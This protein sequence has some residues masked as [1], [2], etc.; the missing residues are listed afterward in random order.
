MQWKMLQQ[1]QPMDIV[2]ATGMQ[3]SV[4]EFI[5]WAAEDLGISLEFRGKGVEETAVVAG[6]VGDRAPAVKPGDVILRI[7]PKY[8]RPAEVETLL[9]DPS[10]ARDKL[11]WTPEITA[12]AMCAEM[13]EVDLRTAQRHAFL[14]N[15]GYN[16]PVSLE[17]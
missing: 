7:D 9:G 1:D 2:I 17:H 3:H 10:L 14:A 12:R 4:R 5:V 11:G 13:I 6:V 15:H 16:A 8:F